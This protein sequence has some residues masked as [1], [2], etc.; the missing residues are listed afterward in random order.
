MAMA[1][2]GELTAPL[3][4]HRLQTSLDNADA[5][6]MDLARRGHA[7]IHNDEASGAVVYRFPDIWANPERYTGGSEHHGR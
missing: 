5:M 3:V 4:A 6:L 2:G 7:E 1:E